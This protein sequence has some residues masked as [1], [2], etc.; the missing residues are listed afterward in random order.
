MIIV[1]K[2]KCVGCRNCVRDCFGRNMAIK[3]GKAKVIWD[4]CMKCGHCVAV[5]PANAIVFD[6]YDQSEIIECE[7]GTCLP[8]A[9]QY[10]QHLKSRRSIRHFTEKQVEQEK[11]EYILEAGRYSPTGG[12]LQNVSY[13]V[14]RDEIQEIKEMFI[15][16]LYEMALELD[17]AGKQ[18]SWYSNFWKTMYREYHSEAKKDSLFFDAGTVILVTSNS[19]QSGIIAAAH[20]ETM[21]YAQDLG[22][23]YSGFTCSA[24]EHSEKIREYLHMKPDYHAYACLVIGYPDVKYYRTVPRKPADIEWR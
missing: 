16:E 12:N 17:K 5:C 6:D 13:I 21:V 11:L 7:S 15:D 22:M 9:K 19:P 20:M 4:G 1:D 18:V 14:I 10:L 24:V 23:L 8:D 3:D 2:E